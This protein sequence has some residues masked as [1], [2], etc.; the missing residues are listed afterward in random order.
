MNESSENGLSTM[1]S[2]CFYLSFCTIDLI[3]CPDTPVPTEDFIKPRSTEFNWMAPLSICSLSSES[4]SILLSALIY[5][6]A[7]F[8][9]P[10][11]GS[12]SWIEPFLASTLI[13]V[14]LAACILLSMLVLSL[15]LLERRLLRYVSRLLFWRISSFGRPLMEPCADSW[16]GSGK[17]N[18]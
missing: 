14:G 5:V 15:I 17:A 16:P 3:V 6:P 4:Y 9:Y 12:V 8:S 2:L 10:L 1:Y 18:D 7:P 13:S 11:G